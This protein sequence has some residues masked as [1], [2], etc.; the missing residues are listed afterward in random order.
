MQIRLRENMRKAQI[1]KKKNTGSKL[2]KEKVNNDCNTK[3]RVGVVDRRESSN[4]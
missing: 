2:V 3:L 4:I 1:K